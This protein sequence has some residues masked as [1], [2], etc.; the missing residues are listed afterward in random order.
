MVAQDLV[1]Y[2]QEMNS[3]VEHALEYINGYLLEQIN[4]PRPERDLTD[5]GI[6][7]INADKGYARK[8]LENLYFPKLSGELRALLESIDTGDDDRRVYSSF[9]FST[10][11]FEFTFH[12]AEQRDH[13][14]RTLDDNLIAIAGPKLALPTSCRKDVSLYEFLMVSYETGTDSPFLKVKFIAPCI[15]QKIKSQFEI[16]DTRFEIEQELERKAR[17]YFT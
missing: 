5:Q 15:G 9:Y 4:T 2:V 14:R 6:Q 3:P 8:D 13:F 10:H 7:V 11:G 16:N 12:N 1:N 17:A